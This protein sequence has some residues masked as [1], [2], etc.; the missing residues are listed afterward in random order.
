MISHRT[1]VS[2]ILLAA[3][4][5][6]CHA[7]TAQERREPDPAK[8]VSEL[9]NLKAR[10]AQM[11]EREAA[12]DAEETERLRRVRVFGDIGFRFHLISGTGPV[13]RAVGGVSET[14]LEGLM[15][16][17]ATGFLFDTDK[18][19]MRYE[20]RISLVG[21]G[22]FNAPLGAPTVGWRPVDGLGSGSPVAVD[23]LL[24]EHTYKKWLRIEGGRFAPPFR[25]SQAIFDS[26]LA[27]T[28]MH[29]GLDLGRF[30]GIP[31]LKG[32]DKWR[33]YDTA[34]R[35]EVS[36]LH[37]HAAGYVFAEDEYGLPVQD[38]SRTPTGASLQVSGKYRFVGTDSSVSFS[39]GAHWFNQAGAA[40]RNLST[41]T[42]FTTTNITNAAGFVPGKFHVADLFLEG[43][44]LEEQ[45][46]SLRIFS[47]LIHNFGRSDS[48]MAFGEDASGLVLGL[49]WGTLEFE[50]ESTF[51]LSYHY[52]YLEPDSAIS[53]FNLDAVNTNYKGHYL[54][55][56][57]AVRADVIPFFDCYYGERVDDGVGGFGVRDDG[58]HGNPSTGKQ[59]R[60]R[61][62]VLITF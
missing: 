60:I 25:G 2:L 34:T 1:A 59:L 33:D 32:F 35:S 36:R 53:E 61:M 7:A 51:R 38:G 37:V 30:T 12:R 42:T 18:H 26:D 31:G 9:E 28:G 47:H 15:R 55:L 45:A 62:G 22:D 52:Y 46:A 41:G 19:R 21:Q 3:T 44:L 14:R 54:G 50:E 27:L 24:I 20:A 39:M 40:S 29:V 57:V 17:G 5:C 11:E 16:L 13:T 58:T 10:V 43:M 56:K 8:T 4:V 6:F 48:P 49:E 23:R